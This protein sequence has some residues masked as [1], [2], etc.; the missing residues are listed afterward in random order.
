[1]DPNELSTSSEEQ[2]ASESIEDIASLL[3]DANAEEAE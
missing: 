3:A 2:G 1:M